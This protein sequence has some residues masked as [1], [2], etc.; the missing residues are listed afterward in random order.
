MPVHRNPQQSFVQALSRTALLPS[1]N[2]ASGMTAYQG[3]IIGTD[4]LPELVQGL[5]KSCKRVND[6]DL[7]NLE[8]IPLSRAK[9]LLV[10]VNYLQ[11]CGT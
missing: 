10:D 5:S 2:G 6:A 8:A 7:S 3:N 1:I 11:Q 9:A 4:D